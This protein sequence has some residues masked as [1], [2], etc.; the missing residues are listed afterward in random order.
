[1]LDP[2]T[3]EAIPDPSYSDA[4]YYAVE[5]QDYAYSAGTVEESALAYLRAGDELDASLPRFASI[6]YGDLPCVFWP[7]AQQDAARPA[8]LTA[9]GIPTLVLNATSDPATPYS[10][11]QAVYAGLDEGYLI[12]ETGGPHIIF[13]W[14]FSCVDDPVT[15]YLVDDQLPEASET[16]CEG[17]VA[18]AFVPLAEASAAGYEDPLEALNS[19]DNEIYYLPEYYYW[20]T[21]TPTT[22]GCPYGGGTLTFQ[23]SDDGEVFTLIECAFSDGFVMTGSGSYNYDEELF[24]LDVTVAGLE[25]GKLVYTRDADGLLHVSGEYGGQAVDL[26]R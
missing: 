9:E 13:A 23:P 22:I 6:F 7:D 19:V 1:V 8:V 12:T 10:N 4:V 26:S 25:S 3:L 2:E 17:I 15:A 5:C 16:T 21:E 14:G 20:D 24:S 18:D 11:A